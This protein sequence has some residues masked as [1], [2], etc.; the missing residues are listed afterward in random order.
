MTYLGKE[1]FACETRGRRDYTELQ[2][3]LKRTSSKT[4]VKDFPYILRIPSTDYFKSIASHKKC[5]LLKS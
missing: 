4:V 3:N 2:K 5:I 1:G